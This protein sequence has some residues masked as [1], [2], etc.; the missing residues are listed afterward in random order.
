VC[1]R[2]RDPGA[3]RH[4]SGRLPTRRVCTRV[5]DPGAKDYDKQDRCQ[6]RLFR[7]FHL[8]PLQSIRRTDSRMATSTG[9]ARKRIITFPAI[10]NFSAKAPSPASLQI[11]AVNPVR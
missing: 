2:V 1:T 9:T 11:W 8:F 3:L 7:I 5:R 4:A 6:N 10:S